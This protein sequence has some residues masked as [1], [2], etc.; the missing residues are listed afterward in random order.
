M[1][2]SNQNTP[3][4][5]PL[6]PAHKVED[7]LFA[8]VA[9]FIALFTGI[10]ALIFL[11]QIFSQFT[12]E[13]TSW[14]TIV[15]CSMVGLG[16]IV[17][18]TI[19]NL[20]RPVHERIILLSISIQLAMLT[21]SA[22]M[23]SAGIAAALISLVSALLLSFLSSTSKRHDYALMIGLTGAVF[24]ALI[25]IYSPF[26]KMTV[27]AATTI[28]LAML[29][30]QLILYIVLLAGGFVSANLRTKLITA[31][32]AI[33]II[34]LVAFS[35][36]QS[37]YTESILR[38]QNYE[39]VRLAA[40]QTASKI[41]DYL[42]SSISTTNVAA[43]II[44]FREF[45]EMSEEQRTDPIMQY[46]MQTLIQ[47]MRGNLQYGSLD[48]IAL[49]DTGGVVVFDTI[50]SAVGRWEGNRD[51]V[52]QPLKTGRSY[53]S[54]VTFDQSGNAAITF[55]API[56]DYNLQ[57]IG[58]LRVRHRAE[59][60][61]K[62]ISA[63]R[64]LL[65]QESYPILVDENMLRL[66]D[67]VD[68]GYLFHPMVP[69]SEAGKSDMLISNR[70]PDLQADME[71]AYF[72]EAASA[73]D[74]YLENPYFTREASVGSSIPFAGAVVKLRTAE[75]Y[76]I[77]QQRP[78][79][80][81]FL[82][83]ETANLTILAA[84]I[85]VAVVSLASLLLARLFSNPILKLTATAE[86]I[87]AGDFTLQAD[88]KSKDEIGMLSTAF[89]TMARQIYTLI[90][91][92]EGRVQERTA[93]LS[94]QNENLK[95]RSQQIQ[96][97]SDVAR[98][99]ASTVELESLLNQVTVLISDRFTFYHVGIFLIDDTGEFA[100]LRAAN[101]EGGKIMLARGHKLKIGAK[102]I[103]GYACGAREA[104]IATD[105]GQDSVYFN[106]PDL[107]LT[108]SEMA[109]PL[110]AGGRVIGA[111]DVQSVEANAFTQDDIELFSI[112]ADQVAIAIVN[113]RLYAE[114]NQALAEIQELHR[115]Y[116]RM[117]WKREVT[118]QNHHSY[119]YTAQGVSAVETVNQPDI[120]DVFVSG[121]PQVKSENE[122]SQDGCS[123]YLAWRTH[124]NHPASRT[125][126][127]KEGLDA[128]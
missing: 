92:L 67:I 119:R 66:A 76:V 49:I 68:T 94:R 95:F 105:V 72:P 37:R 115:R 86:G 20:Q 77:Y 25:S 78:E 59:V 10:L 116:L 31:A 122:L 61:Q 126:T 87:A 1:M 110:K 2:P 112:L 36:V 48:S 109:L 32:L 81:F 118:D 50:S 96:T 8:W 24:T 44:Q 9:L 74:N 121:Q 15:L 82:L 3:A 100:V 12:N 106:N 69:L 124:W 54:P 113:N 21:L 63:N 91:Q 38:D 23:E 11:Y 34:P 127:G 33:A 41:D 84:T 7:W 45:L 35:L 128:R 85:L 88:V 108:R 13:Q 28:L 26:E 104:R 90:H 47:S 43:R 120:D 64:G 114:T 53:S 75:W 42:I 39:N 16:A 99:I 83:S 71:E 14:Q 73:I 60:L 102:G 58:L 27:P 79:K 125:R 89:N 101:S 70:L 123:H 57:L 40:F 65:G 19:S 51:Y 98:S 107:P 97:V 93:E 17:S 111:L 46:E 5:P 4:T 55:S 56:R 52:A 80:L 29:G 62:I 22:L 30:L 18:V 103:V 6:D 117:E